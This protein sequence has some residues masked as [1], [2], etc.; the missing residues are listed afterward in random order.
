MDRVKETT[1][2][3]GIGWMIGS[4]IGSIVAPIPG[5]V[6]GGAVGAAIGVSTYN[7][8]RKLRGKS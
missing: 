7:K 1:V 4:A 8:Y 3:G 5:T 6:V 2:C